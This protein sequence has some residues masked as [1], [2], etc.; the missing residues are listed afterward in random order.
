MQE[1]REAS[2]NPLM[3]FESVDKIAFHRGKGHGA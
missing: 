3:L 1:G 2:V